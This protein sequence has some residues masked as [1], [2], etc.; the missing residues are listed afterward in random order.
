MFFHDHLDPLYTPRPTNHHTVVHVHE[1][2]FL[3][4]HSLHP[5]TFCPTSCHLFSIYESVFVL[6]VSSVCS[7]GSTYEWDHMVFV[8]SDWLFS[9]S[10]MFS[11]SIHTMSKGKFFVFFYGWI[12]S[13]SINVPYL[14]YPF[15]YRWALG[16][17]PYLSNCK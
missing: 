4:A 6:L 7:L 1:S 14:F 13:Q 12:E 5:L 11:M 2:F 15:V 10:M 3:F 8:I 17:L 9:L 16:L